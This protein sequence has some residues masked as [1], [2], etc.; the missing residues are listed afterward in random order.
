MNLLKNAMVAKIAGKMWKRAT[1]EERNQA[2][3]ASTHAREKYY[4]EVKQYKS[5]TAKQWQHIMENWPKRFRVNYN[6]FVM[7]HFGKIMRANPGSKFGAV[8][9]LVANQWARL[10][11][12]EKEPYNQKYAQDRDRF[13]KEVNALWASIH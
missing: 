1:P 10:S 11:P 5:P 2:H 12:T 4:R 9:R 6:F 7:D 13:E 3:A 8:S